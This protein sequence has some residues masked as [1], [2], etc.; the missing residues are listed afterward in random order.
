M[1]PFRVA[2]RAAMRVLFWSPGFLP[3][4]GGIEILAGKF[5]PAMRGRGHE[6]I[7]VAGQRSLAWPERWTYRDIPVYRFPFWQALGDVNRMMQ[8]K[9]Q[10]SVLKRSFAPDLI[11]INGT[12]RDEF[13]HLVTEK[14]CDAPLLVTLHG[15]WLSQADAIVTAV[16]KSA[17]WVA[18][19]SQAILDRAHRLVPEITR[20]SHV[21]PN[22]VEEFPLHPEAL[23]AARLLCLGRLSQE[24]GFDVALDAFA[25]V[26][27]R[28]PEARLVVAGDGPER[29]SLEKQAVDLG[30]SQAV[31]FAGWVA[32]ENVP[33]LINTATMLLMPS[34]Y[35][36]L[37]LAAL[38]AALMAR[39]VVGARVGGLPEIVVH[40]ETGLLIGR[41][42]AGELASAIAF[43]LDQP[44]EA[45]RLGQAARRRAQHAFSWE[46][47]VDSYDT[48]YRNLILDWRERS[49]RHGTA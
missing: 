38:E 19:C 20:R 2:D 4:I 28:Y 33:G 18:G 25:A 40:R 8:V 46:R 17:D 10:I 11:H 24:K 37:P 23:A 39:P 14:A 49:P 1:P 32:P 13:F 22:A 47:H 30:I 29:G 9:Q 15:D 5:L 36:S 43:L 12:G 7:V 48:L 44:E 21:I 34:R 35:E 42:D 3:D 16:L 6:Y 41:E 45:D 26:L 27:A 31:E